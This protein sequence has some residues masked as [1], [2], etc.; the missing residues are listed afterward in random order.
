MAA[1]TFN[2]KQIFFTDH[3][4]VSL[5]KRRINE[6]MVE[7]ALQFGRHIYANGAHICF[8]GRKEVQKAKTKGIDIQELESLN[9]ILQECDGKIVLITGFKNS[10]LKRYK[11]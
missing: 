4:R 1:K 7:K 6:D 9:L 5:N 2:T 10:S 3:S 8:V 11:H